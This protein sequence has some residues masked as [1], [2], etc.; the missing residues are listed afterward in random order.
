MLVD[1]LLQ[2]QVVLHD[3]LQIGLVTDG[4]YHH[5]AGSELGVHLVV[6]N[7]INALAIQRRQQ[8]LAHQGLFILILRGHGHQLACTYQLG[9]GGGD[10][11]V[12]VGT[13]DAELYVVKLGDIVRVLHLGI[14]QGGYARGAP[15]HRVRP[16]VHQVLLQKAQEGDLRD[17]AVV[18]CVGLVV[19]GGVHALPQHLELPGHLIDEGVGE[20]RAQ[21]DVLLPGH[22]ELGDAVLLLH[23][24]LGRRP[25]DVEAQGE[26]DVMATHPT[27]AG[28]EVDQ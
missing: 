27:V 22:G 1:G 5:H 25:I 24:D 16:L 12:L 19:D 26:E 23:L 9:A 10:D 28:R 18:G 21:V 6:G 4:A 2:R 15:V 20:L 3:P 14:R 13:L 7:D 11:D 17:A 8:G